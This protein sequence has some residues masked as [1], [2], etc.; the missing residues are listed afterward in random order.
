MVPSLTDEVLFG[1]D[2]GGKLFDTLWEL[3]KEESHKVLA[4]TRA[5][6]LRHKEQDQ[7]NARKYQLDQATPTPL[8][9]TL[10][11]PQTEPTV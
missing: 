9:E 4:V 3:E 1:T 8:E 6:V 10:E 7:E 5:Q 11:Q 2:V